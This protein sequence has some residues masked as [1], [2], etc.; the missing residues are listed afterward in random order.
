ML[1]LHEI[2]IFLNKLYYL[3][4]NNNQIIMNPIE[5]LMEEHDLIA[6]MM[7]LF[8]KEIERLKQGQG[9]FCFIHDAIDFFKSYGDRTHHGKEEDILFRELGQ[10]NLSEEHRNQMAELLEEHVLAREK[11]KHLNELNEKFI[12]GEHDVQIEIVSV[13]E[14][15]SAFYKQHIEKENT[16]FFVSANEY[17]NEDEWK[18]M[19]DEFAEF[20]R[21]VIHEKY[22]ALIADMESRNS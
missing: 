8:G 4:S 10:K 13:L 9:S 5:F 14:D 20:D 11:I 1:I 6:K 19:M 21:S 12:K 16:H 22:K 3:G 15:L 7:T 2:D 17:M 18:R